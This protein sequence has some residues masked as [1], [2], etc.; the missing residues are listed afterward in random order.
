MRLCKLLSFALISMRAFVPVAAANEVDRS[1]PTIALQSVV[2][3]VGEQW[4]CPLCRQPVENRDRFGMDLKL[5]LSEWHDV[6]IEEAY[7]KEKIRYISDAELVASLSMPAMDPALRQALQAEDNDRISV[8]LHD[9]FLAR[10]DNH[11][12]STYDTYNR[13]YF[14]TIDEFLQEVRADSHRTN[15]IVRSAQT[16]YT[17]ERGFTLF[18]VHWGDRIDFNHTYSNA[19]KWGVHYLSFLDDQINYFLLTRDPQTARAFETVFNQWY[20]QLD[21][22]QQEP[23]IH[24]QK[25]YDFIWYELGLANRTQ[26]FID[27]ARVFGS[28]LSPATHK[29]LLKIILGSSRWLE[30]C[31]EKTPFH[32]Y[33]WQTHTAFT[34]SY[35]AAAFPEFAE[36]A[37]W[38]ALGK[39]YM[40]LHFENDIRDDGGYVERTP[41]YASYMFSVFYRYM[42]M[43]EYFLNDPS[44][45]QTYLPRLEKFIEYFVLTQTPVGVN[46]PFNDAARG[47]DLVTLFKEMSVFF[48]RGDFLGGVRNEF[49]A[50]TLAAL[51]VTVRQPGITSIDFPDSRFVVLRDSWQPTSYYLMLN[52]GEW[53]NHTHYDQL[54]FEIYANGVPIAVD[55][56]IGRL[57]YLDSLHVSWYKH[58]LAHNM[59]TINQA[60]PEKRDRPGYDKVWAPLT[61][62]E[63]FAAT[64]DGYLEYQKARHRR[65]VVFAKK[66]YWLIIDQVY[67]EGKGREMDFNLHTPCSMSAVEDGFVSLEET[68]FLIKQDHQAA[69]LIEKIKDKGIADLRG[70][71]AEPSHREID[72]LI[73]RKELQGDPFV[74]RMATLIYPFAAKRN[75]SADEITVTGRVLKD[76]AAVGY[77][78]KTP[79]REDLIIVSDGTHR[80]FTDD[81]AGDFTH[82]W[83]SYR[84]GRLHAAA[85]TAVSR[86]KVKGMKSLSFKTKREYE[87]K[88]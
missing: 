19:S 25:S 67:A 60:V 38:L 62:V 7:F 65:H 18:G 14:I 59:V 45:R 80:R 41:G 48:R 49:S 3:Q 2:Y 85:F 9:Y 84:D 61:N 76:R 21:S 51:P 81:I 42:M 52:Y 28:H 6:F 72:W 40:I 73:F 77:V 36:S 24:Y 20:D 58:P 35:A 32:P 5:C 12:L 79:D 8:L 55:A 69:P 17:P 88:R 50:E 68:G 37:D 4:H 87:F 83:F 34:L 16:F 71:A 1:G 39:K 15:A 43:M 75:L 11:R 27:A 57:G 70:L 86:C 23:V 54:D 31:L 46:A 74:D 64:H 26:K 10:P 66:R 30:Q 47:K 13:K 82:G 22:V 78:V 44:M 29:R 56:G 33:N 63:F 53:Q